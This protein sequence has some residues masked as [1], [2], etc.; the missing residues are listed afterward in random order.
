MSGKSNHKRKY[1]KERNPFL[2]VIYILAVLALL[3]CLV[4]LVRQR[5]EEH[6]LYEAKLQQAKESETIEAKELS[7]AKEETTVKDELPEEAEQQ[8]DTQA[9]A[10][11]EVPAATASPTATQVPTPTEEPQPHYQAAVVILNGTGKEGLAGKW[12]TS[13]GNAGYGNVKAFNYTKAVEDHT[14]IYAATEEAGKEFLTLFPQGEVR[15]GSIQEGIVE[16]T[17]RPVAPQAD[18]YIVLGTNES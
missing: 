18:V 6:A 13:V 5:R 17:T 15:V 3:G 14:V 10:P 1:K 4:F 7:W 12:A 9:P 11:T 16:G 2:M 8:E